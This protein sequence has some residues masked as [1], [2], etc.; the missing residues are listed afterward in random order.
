MARHA[1]LL[2]LPVLAGLTACTQDSPKLPTVTT[3]TDAKQ[4]HYPLRVVQQG[5]PSTLNIQISIQPDGGLLATVGH[6]Q[7]TCS[8][9]KAVVAV[10]ND[11]AVRIHTDPSASAPP[12]TSVGSTQVLIADSQ[13]NL[14]NIDDP[15][16]G[17]ARKMVELLLR[18][19]TGPA[20]KR[21]TCN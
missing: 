15:R 1:A 8:L 14:V 16:V 17:V 4:A 5:G 2:L 9:D 20:D 19:L 11:A 7:V 21:I 10:L 13:S 6:D 3:T 12:P 18:D